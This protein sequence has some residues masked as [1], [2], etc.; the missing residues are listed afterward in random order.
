MK[1]ILFTTCFLFSIPFFTQTDSTKKNNWWENFE[2]DGYF[3]FQFNATNKADSLDLHT[4]SSGDFRRFSNNKFMVRRSRIQ[5]MYHLNNVNTSI[6]FDMNERGLQIKDAWLSVKDPWFKGLELTTG[7]FALPFGHEIEL[8]SQIR[9]SPERSRVIQHLF[10]GIRDVG[11][12]VRFQMPESSKFDF[13]RLDGG[14]Y[15][16]TGSN[17]ESDNAKDFVGRFM[18]DNPLKSEKVNFSLAYSY[19][20]GKIRHQYDIDG[21]FSNYHY[22]YNHKDTTFTVDGVEQDYRVEQ[23]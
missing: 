8:T 19:L 21:S 23:L 13:L 15:H 4:M 20:Q 16:G 18:I 6:S 14:I 3:Q 10:P 11:A 2:I 12:N 5:I 9:E 1:I 22:I 7:V 17:I